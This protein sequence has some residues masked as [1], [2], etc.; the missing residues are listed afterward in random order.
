MNSWLIDG[1]NLL[2][3]NEL[4][5]DEPGRDR[6]LR[7]L[8]SR[9]GGSGSEV[10]VVFDSRWAPR[11]QREKIAGN[12]TAVF[13]AGSADEYI[14]RTVRGSRHPRSITVVTDDREIIRR[15]GRERAKHC[16]CREFI[17][18]IHPPADEVARPEK[19]EADNPHEIRRLLELWGE[20]TNQGELDRRRR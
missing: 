10:I 5:C 20:E 4:S 2:Y 16:T 18:M 6:L 1:Y 14:V 13:A 7:S 3:G 12:I 19:P 15:T 9:F 8:D 17:E 11:T